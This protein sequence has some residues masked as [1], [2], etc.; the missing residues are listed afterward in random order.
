METPI[1]LKAIDRS[2]LI[3]APKL[4]DQRKLDDDEKNYCII[5]QLIKARNI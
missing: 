4:I 3:K 5:V 2:N 1:C